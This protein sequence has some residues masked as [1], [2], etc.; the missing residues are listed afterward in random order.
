MCTRIDD[1][2]RSIAHSANMGVFRMKCSHPKDGDV[3]DERTLVA[4]SK[5]EAVR[6][7]SDALVL[8]GKIYELHEYLVELYIDTGVSYVSSGNVID[9]H[10]VAV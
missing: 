4:S 3:I 8:E 7:Y 10:S 6:Y 1:A 5:A 9:R 2:L